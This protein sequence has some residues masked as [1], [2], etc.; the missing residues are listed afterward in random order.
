VTQRRI[1][2]VLSIVIALSRFAA[3]AHSMFDWDEAL[4][5][6]GVRSYD[7]PVH[8]PHPPGYPLYI[9]A[10]KVIALTGLDAFRCLQIVVLLGAIFIF[11]A[12]YFLAR[13]IGFDFPTAIGG[14]AVYAFLPNVWLYGGTGFSDVPATTLAF[15]ACA[16]LLRGR[17]DARA[18]IGGAVV[19]GIAAGIRPANLLVG[20]VPALL[21]T[22]A[23]LRAKSYRA[24]AAAISLGA[25]IVAGSYLGAAL[26]SRSVPEYIAI[27]RT[28]S[29]YVHD[30]DSWHNPRRP[31]LFEAAKEFFLWP[32]WQ[33]DVL[34]TMAI[35]ATLSTIAAIVRRRLQPLLTLAIFAPLAIT[36]WLN[37]D[38][39]T[40]SRYAVGYM[41]VHVLLAADGFLLFGR[42]VQVALCAAIVIVLC[43]WT[44]PGL[45][46][47]RTTDSPPIAALTWIRD[48]VPR[49]ETVFV[50]GSFGPQSDY[51]LAD[52]PP[53]FF[54]EPEDIP[55]TMGD[56]WVV[57][58]RIHEGGQSFVLPHKTLWRVL[59]RRN[60]EASVS[61]AAGLIRFGDGWHSAEGTG[62]HTWTWMKQ[63]GSAFLP[64]IRGSGVASL[65]IHVP[66]DALPVPPTIEVRWNGQ[67]I[68][69]FVATQ[70]D[71]ERSWTLPSRSGAVNELRL[72][73]S[74]TVT[75]ASRG[76]STDTRALGLRLD[77][78]SW[79]PAQ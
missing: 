21:A 58:W 53:N 75:P 8:R 59:R 33:H 12:L 22:W 43:V 11:P 55:A 4:F 71:L 3:V 19:L 1:L 46:S 20:A 72:V 76:D 14:A 36:S 79:M 68:E 49:T 57:D 61:R 30:V 54:E 32:F 31:P 16:L 25:L 37:L 15:L 35:G 38:I 51:M 60:F 6:L 42:K 78:L 48:N 29:K 34:N 44:W 28:Q 27:I 10:A 26:A 74:A 24:V 62:A 64:A 50:Q 40:A 66:L 18:Y 17:R 67:T 2:L 47:Q 69:R 73:T 65:R 9:A 52:R 63:E 77:H 56:A 70:A 5:S 7:V 45:R 39:S 13:E 41:A 23:Q